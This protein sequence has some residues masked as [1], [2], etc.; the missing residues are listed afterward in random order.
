MRLALA[1]WAVACAAQSRDIPI[2]GG[3]LL[4]VD[5]NAELTVG[6]SRVEIRRGKVVYR[7]VDS[8]APPVELVTPVVSVH[9]YLRGDYRIEV[10]KSGEAAITPLGGDVKVSAPQG[11]EW[12]PVGKKMLVRGPAASPRFRIVS[13]L[14]GWR[15]IAEGLRTAMKNSSGGASVDAD[16]SSGSDDSSSSRSRPIGPP[17]AQENSVG[18]GA[19]AGD[20]RS[21]SIPSRG[22]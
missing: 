22:R 21:G 19:A 8:G 4:Q 16:V 6:E 15:W 12:L 11:D 17:P 20:A 1:L 5:R 13:G 7:I 18:R 3:I 10:K 14:T 2:H 9:P